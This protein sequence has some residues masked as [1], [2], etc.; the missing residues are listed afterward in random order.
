[1]GLDMHLTGDLYL[2]NSNEKDREIAK[3]VD[4]LL[5]RLDFDSGSSRESKVKSIGIDIMY[6]RKAN[7]IHEFFVDTVQYGDDD[8]KRYL[9]ED[10]QLQE[11]IE[12]CKQEL[13]ARG[14]DEAGTFLEPAEGFFFGSKDLDDYYYDELQRTADGLTK[15]L[16]SE[17]SKRCDIYYQSSW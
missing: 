14:T 10:E 5:E 3:A 4:T 6:W 13:N 7:A 8:C 17:L 1:M 11:L 16:E 2:W 15:F 9:V 12:L